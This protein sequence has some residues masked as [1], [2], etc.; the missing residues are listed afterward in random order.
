MR[1]FRRAECGVTL[2]ARSKHNKKDDPNRTVIIS[3]FVDAFIQIDRGDLLELSIVIGD[4]KRRKFAGPLELSTA[5]RDQLIIAM[6]QP[7]Q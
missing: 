2:M 5:E 7:P 1:A 4:G 6:L 3:S